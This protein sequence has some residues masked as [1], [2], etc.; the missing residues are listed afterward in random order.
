MNESARKKWDQK[1]EIHAAEKNEKQK[2][3]SKLYHDSWWKYI[4]PLLPEIKNGRILEAG[5]GTGR[6]AQ[7][8]VP[9]G[10]TMVLSDFSPNMIVK[11]EEFAAQKGYSEGVSFENLDVCN[12][13]TLENNSFDMVISSGVPVSL[14]SDPRQA[15]KEF[16]RVVRPGGYVLCD[17]SNKNR[18][19]YDLFCKSLS[20][21]FLDILKTGV[22][23][24]NNGMKLNLL[25]PAEFSNIFADEKMELCTMAGILPM[26]NF[27]TE[28]PFV[29][30]MED[31]STY[32][33]MEVVAQKYAEQPDIVALSSRLLA[34]ARKPF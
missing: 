4:Q 10:F 3:I 29:K 9:M 12:L 1:A 21:D 13:E 2:P 28:Q 16:C 23:V 5:C 18:Y 22:H 34:V 7:F 32:K 27:P 24:T 15:I 31:N 26:F 20:G 8:L 25:G 33:A 19:A 30:S 17:A 14:C 6:W 11:A